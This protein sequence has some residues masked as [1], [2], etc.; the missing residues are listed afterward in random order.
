MLDKRLFLLPLIIIVMGCI[1][2]SL[3]F[4]ARATGSPGLYIEKFTSDQETISP[5]ETTGINL[6]ISNGGEFVASD[7][8]ATL[9]GLG[10]LD[11]YNSDNPQHPGD[12]DPADPATGTPADKRE[13]MW[14]VQAPVEGKISGTSGYK[15]GVIVDYSY[16]SDGWAE[17]LVT[18]KYEEE[19]K[20]RSVEIPAKDLAGVV[21]PTQKKSRKTGDP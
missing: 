7:I 18:E 14:I 15:I 12:L 1:S 8:E 16:G 3:P 9:F 19:I 20:K 13:L 5:E 6:R 4:G 21:L 2:T 10:E 17:M 11:L